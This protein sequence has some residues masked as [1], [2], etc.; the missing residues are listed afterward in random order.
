VEDAEM[1][2]RITPEGLEACIAFGAAAIAVMEARKSVELAGIVN[3]PAYAACD[4]LTAA[5]EDLRRLFV[6]GDSAIVPGLALSV[7]VLAERVAI[8]IE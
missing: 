4:E 6:G 3:G 5:H 8:L 1:G 7:L 2:N